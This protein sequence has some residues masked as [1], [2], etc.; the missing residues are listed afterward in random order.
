MIRRSVVVRP[1]FQCASAEIVRALI[2]IAAL[3]RM[4]APLKRICGSTESVHTQKRH[5][6][7]ELVSEKWANLK[8]AVFTLQRMN[9]DR[10]ASA[11]LGALSVVG[12]RW[13]SQGD[14]PD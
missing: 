14:Y 7:R 10:P 2:V 8:V 9:D 4:G 12:A 11:G 5:P 6:R 13:L 1:S 3:R